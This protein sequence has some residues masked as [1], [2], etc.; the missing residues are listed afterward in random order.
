M[1][2]EVGKIKKLTIQ[3]CLETLMYAGLH[4]IKQILDNDRI[5]GVLL[6]P[7]DE[8]WRKNLLLVEEAKPKETLVLKFWHRPGLK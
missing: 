5:L 7:G 6:Q 2:Y 4:Q 3:V 8:G 1:F